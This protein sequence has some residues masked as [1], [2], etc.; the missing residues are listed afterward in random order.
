MET[1]EALSSLVTPHLGPPEAPEGPLNGICEIGVKT[2]SGDQ[3][4]QT[5]NVRL[6]V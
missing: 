6:E 1:F 4:Q 5:K 2:P 3:C